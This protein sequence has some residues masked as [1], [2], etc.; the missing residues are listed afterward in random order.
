M[1]PLAWR[2]R[3]CACWKNSN[4]AELFSPISLGRKLIHLVSCKS[5][6]V[7][8]LSSVTLQLKRQSSG[9][10]PFSNNSQ[11]GSCVCVS[12]SNSPPTSHKCQ[13]SRSLWDL[14]CLQWKL[15]CCLTCFPHRDPVWWDSRHHSRHSFTLHSRS[16]LRLATLKLACDLHPSSSLLPQNSQLLVIRRS[17]YHNGPPYF[18]SLLASRGALGSGRGLV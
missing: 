7:A 11:F 5:L 1:C 6:L 15:Q 13:L 9:R 18:E 10:S 8:I 2:A 14:L 12:E 4:V 17:E 16:V 3:A